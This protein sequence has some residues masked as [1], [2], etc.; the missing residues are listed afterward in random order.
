MH[1][2]CN[3]G[4]LSTRFVRGA[5]NGKAH[6]SA[7]QIGNAAHWVNR[8]IGWTSCHQDFATRQQFRLKLGNQVLDDFIGF[9]HAPIACFTTGLV[10]L[11]NTEHQRP[12]LGEL[13]HIALGSGIDPHFTVHRRGQDQRYFTHRSGQAHEA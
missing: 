3:H 10:A 11:P 9:E 7:G 12:V 2:A 6:F 8:F 1:R 13:R 5:G 4:H